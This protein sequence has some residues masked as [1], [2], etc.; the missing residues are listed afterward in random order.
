M[1]YENINNI[2]EQFNVSIPKMYHYNREHKDEIKH[3]VDIF[4][5]IGNNKEKVLAALYLLTCGEEDDD[6]K[7]YRDKTGL[8]NIEYNCE[9]LIEQY[10]VMLLTAFVYNNSFYA[11]AMDYKG[12]IK[13]GFA[14]GE[15]KRDSFVTPRNW[16]DI[17]KTEEHNR[18]SNI[19]G[20]PGSKHGIPNIPNK[21]AA[22][23]AGAEKNNSENSF[24]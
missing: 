17:E 8:N 13:A 1:K 10:K 24:E 12:F 16:G 6:I 20:F 3:I 5:L 7:K 14:I 4:N 21:I 18:K 9:N 2:C 19:I 11:R 22:A 23:P 15:I